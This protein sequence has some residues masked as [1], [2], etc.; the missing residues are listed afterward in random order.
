MTGT[1]FQD[2]EKLIQ[3][4]RENP[5]G[6]ADALYAVLTMVFEIRSEALARAKAEVEALRWE[7]AGYCPHCREDAVRISLDPVDID[8]GIVYEVCYCGA[9]KASWV[10]DEPIKPEVQP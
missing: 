4:M 10:K 1:D 3:S 6:V 8:E 7:D 9:C 5:S 2:R